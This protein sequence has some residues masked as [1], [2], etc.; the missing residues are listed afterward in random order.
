MSKWSIYLTYLA[1]LANLW[2]LLAYVVHFISK[3]HE[4]TL[5]VS[6]FI[7]SV[8]LVYV[9]SSKNMIRVYI[10]ILPLQKKKSS[11]L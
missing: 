3:C 4:T 7:Y 5:L 11:L 8:N 9:F 1:N 6:A 10:T 2:F